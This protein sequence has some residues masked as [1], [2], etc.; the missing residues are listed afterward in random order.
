MATHNGAALLAGL[1]GMTEA[2]ARALWVDVQANQR[3][4]E[5]CPRHNFSRALD[6]PGDRVRPRWRCSTCTGTVDSMAKLWYE[7]GLEHAGRA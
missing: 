7:R 2:E 6:R 1:G 3:L 5:S 4:L